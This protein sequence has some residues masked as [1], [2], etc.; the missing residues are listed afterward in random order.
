[1]RFWLLLFSIALLCSCSVQKRKYQKG[2]YFS[3]KQSSKNNRQ[4]RIAVAPQQK[5]EVP[6]NEP[7]IFAEQLTASA[8]QETGPDLKS[9]TQ[10]KVLVLNPDTCDK[11]VFRDGKEIR[12]KILEIG[13]EEVKYR[14]CDMV[15]GPLFV[16]RKADLFMINFANGTKEVYETPANVVTHAPSPT[17]PTYG[18]YS[19]PD[20]VRRDAV[21]SLV[22]GIVGIVFFYYGSIHAIILG[23]RVLKVMEQYPAVNSS[24]GMARAGVI[25]GITKLALLVLAVALTVLFMI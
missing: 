23:R 21:T 22:L 13:T 11:I 2:F 7:V 5:R 20:N 25:L 10:K 6:V 1:M 4:E 14:K 9:F 12:A 3:G 16:S 24:E 17:L 18:R 8:M 15:D 19:N